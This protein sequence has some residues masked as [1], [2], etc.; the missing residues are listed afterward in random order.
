M[1]M[2]TEEKIINLLDGKRFQYENLEYFEL[3]EEKRNI[4]AK[5]IVEDFFWQ[6]RIDEGYKRFYLEFIEDRIQQFIN[7]DKY[8]AADLYQRMKL[9]IISRVY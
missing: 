5:T 1:N 3:E 2:T 6:M 9:Q 7:E 8:E 4:I